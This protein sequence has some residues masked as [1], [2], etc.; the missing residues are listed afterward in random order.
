M[1]MS[2]T[3][4]SELYEEASTAVLIQYCDVLWKLN[5]NPETI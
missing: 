2:P 1:T 5:M 4:V 3:I